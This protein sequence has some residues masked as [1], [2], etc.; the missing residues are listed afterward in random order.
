MDSRFVSV[1]IALLST[2]LL[3]L[4]IALTLA[5]KDS[6]A[7]HSGALT[8]GRIM[9]WSV[10]SCA[11]LTV[12]GLGELYAAEFALNCTSETNA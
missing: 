7:S 3:L 1:V 12:G 4:S 5:N 2:Y 10:M 11:A 6:D 8:M 9:R